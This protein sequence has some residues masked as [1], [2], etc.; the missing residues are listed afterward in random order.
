MLTNL[1]HETQ[2]ILETI[3]NASFAELV[4]RAAARTPKICLPGNARN[5]MRAKSYPSVGT[6]SATKTLYRVTKS[7]TK[8]GVCAGLELLQGGRVPGINYV[9]EHVTELQTPAQYAN[10]MLKGLLPAGDKAASASYNWVSIF[11]NGGI[12]QQTFSKSGIKL[13]AGLTGSTPEE[14]IFNAFGTIKNNDN[15]LILDTLTNS[16]KTACW[17]LFQNIIGAKKWAAASHP[18]RVELLLRIQQGLIRYMNKDDAQNALEYTYNAQQAIWQAFD[19]AATKANTALVPLTG[20]SFAQQHKAWYEDFL[21]EFTGN[22]QVFLQGKLT[23][24]ISYWTSPQAVKDY[25]A[26]AAKTITATLKTQLANLGTEV[27]VKTGWLK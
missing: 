27:V 5:T 12:F 10:F 2:S 14:A 13:P 1:D 15:L 17:S 26:P 23:Q 24:E 20:T 7:L 19:T 11:G 18:S 3:R 9:V 4:P 6:L 8:D 21:L 25:S 22:I 16:V